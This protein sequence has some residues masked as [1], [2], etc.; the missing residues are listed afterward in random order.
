MIATARRIG[1]WARNCAFAI[2]GFIIMISLSG[3]IGSSIPRGGNSEA[4]PQ[5]PISIMVET[6]GLHTQ[7]VVPVTT[8]HHDWRAT[9]PSANEWLDGH[10]PTHLGIGFGEKVVYQD[11]PRWSDLDVGTALR[12]AA[13]G[14]DG[15][16]RVSRYLNPP[17]SRDRR[18]LALTSD[19]YRALV[20]TI[21]SQ[22]PELGDS[23]FREFERGLSRRDAFYEA[24]ERY[25]LI[26]SC[27]QWTSDRLAGAGIRTGLWTP[28]SGGVMKWLPPYSTDLSVD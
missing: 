6:N 18:E 11:T 14:G 23:G 21:E 27:N 13:V 16:I 7:I 10:A 22:L 19:Q 2:I 24:N 20:S 15:V 5:P 12:V 26:N 28:F 17:Q 8:E 1:G 3:W 9:F 4:I 25:T